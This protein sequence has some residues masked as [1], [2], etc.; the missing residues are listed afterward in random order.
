[1]NLERL[2]SEVDDPVLRN[3]RP[4]VEALLG[5]PVDARSARRTPSRGW[6]PAGRGAATNI[7]GLGDLDDER[8]PGRVRVAVGRGVARHHCD[9]RLRLGGVVERD[10]KL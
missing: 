3:S 8:G 6:G 9:V 1:M 10:R 5:L 2:V 4:R 7:G